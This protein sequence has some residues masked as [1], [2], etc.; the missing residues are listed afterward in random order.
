MDNTARLHGTTPVILQHP[1]YVKSIL[2]NP[3]GLPYIVTGSEDEDIR[4][5]DAATLDGD[6]NQPVAIVSGHCGEVSALVTWIKD[7]GGKKEV[8][9]V[10]AGLDAT[11]RRWSIDGASFPI[12][13]RE[14][15][16]DH[17]RSAQPGAVKL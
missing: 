5:W 16:V 11:L 12:T 1:S 17:R 9:I 8:I 10:S 3:N 14:R 13:S 2:P 6:H 4:V 7:A 15:C